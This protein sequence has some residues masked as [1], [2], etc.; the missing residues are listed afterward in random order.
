MARD[1]VQQMVFVR[2][3]R[4]TKR[5]K[6]KQKLATQYSPQIKVALYMYL[7]DLVTSFSALQIEQLPFV[8][9]KSVVK[10]RA[11]VIGLTSCRRGSLAA[12]ATQSS[13]TG[14]GVR[15]VKNL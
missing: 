7:S 11:L 13:Q 15:S 3:S 12:L 8:R 5:P 10:P 1:I 14:A 6:E 2:S 4:S 9:S